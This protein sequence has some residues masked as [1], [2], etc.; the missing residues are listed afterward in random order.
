MAGYQSHHPRVPVLV[1]HH[2]GGRL[3]IDLGER[4]RQH[5][6]LDLAAVL[7]AGVEIGGQLPGP[8]LRSGGE[9]FESQIGFTQPTGGVEPGR[10][11]EGHVTRLDLPSQAELLERRPQPRPARRRQA[12][13]PLT[14]QGPVF[15]QQRRDVGDGSD[16]GQIAELE[17]RLEPQLLMN[18]PQQVQGHAG[19]GELRKSGL[20]Q[21]RH[22]RMNDEARRQGAAGVVVIRHDHLDAGGLQPF[23][24]RKV[25]DAAV[26]GHEQIGLLCVRLDPIRM[27]PVAVRQA[28]GNERGDAAPEGAQPQHQDRGAGDAIGVVIAMNEDLSPV[29][30]GVDQ[31]LGSPFQIGNSGQRQ[32]GFEVCQGVLVK[33]TRPHH[34]GQ[35]RWDSELPDQPLHDRGRRRRP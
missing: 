17:R 10:Q 6:L 25:A 15:T 13:Q 31:A 2:D 28:V 11:H 8:S 7:V 3:R 30:H 26:D 19:P 9:Q 16:G 35:H 27:D 14:D 5:L 1:G 12:G 20:R 4:L 23:D 24:L 34:A 33:T 18:G 32:V 22:G 21:R 29:L